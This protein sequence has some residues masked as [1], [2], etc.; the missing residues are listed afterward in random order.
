M[1]K[2]TL[3]EKT[4]G[5]FP[6]ISEY[7]NID[8]NLIYFDHAATSQ[9]PK[10]VLQT[11][12]NY[13]SRTNAN[14][15]RGAHQLSA[16]ATEAF[17]EARQITA[18]FIGAKNS[19]EIVFTRNAT[20]AINLV[21][22]SWGNST[23]KAGDE[24]LLTIME[25]HSNLV[26]WQLLSQRTNCVLKHIGI[27][28]NGE[29]DIADLKSKLTNKT[30]LISLV[31][32]SNTLGCCNPIQE[33]ASLAKQ[34]DALVLV[35]ACQSLAHQKIDL[36]K[37]DIDFLVGSAHK[38][39]GPT[40]I[41]FLWGKEKILEIMPPFLGGGE[42]I[43]EAFLEYSTWGDL[44]HKFEAGTPAIGEAIAMGSA[45]QYI[46]NLGLKN[47]HQ[48]EKILTQHLFENLQC[49]PD[50]KILGPTPKQQNNRG[51]LATFSVKGLHSNDIS[52]ILDTKGICIRSGHHCCQ[53]LH[54]YYGLNSTARAS[55]SFTSTIQEINLFSEALSETIGFL[56]SNS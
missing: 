54:R 17:E 14:V 44:P 20:E 18:E 42:M 6:L 16:M 1:N 5:D 30:K 24:I 8:N 49:I 28:D 34:V 45:I 33:V 47:I 36:N 3:A 21:A 23:I 51:A 2:P 50:I 39:C 19:R 40:G 55:L 37:L 26:P 29:L 31:H 32:I 53:P 9:K 48:W 10:K 38:F 12:E 11:I 22:H 56:K 52:E 7:S 25:H 41:G 15:H 4:R 46:Q 43:E 27:T 35:D 13:Y